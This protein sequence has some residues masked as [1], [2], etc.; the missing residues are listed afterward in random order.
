MGAYSFDHAEI[1]VEGVAVV[2]EDACNA[3][4]VHS[5]YQLMTYLPALAH[6]A[7]DQ[8]PAVALALGHGV[9]GIH[10]AFLRDRVGLVKLLYVCQPVSFCGND[11]ERSAKSC[12]VTRSV[13]DLIRVRRC[14]G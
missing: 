10:E 6:P 4:A 5:R 8:L 1:S 3:E 14:H 12:C 7:D 9:D 11:V 13:E 2:H